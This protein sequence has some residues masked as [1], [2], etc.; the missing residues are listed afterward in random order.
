[1]LFA[2]QLLFH[3]VHQPTNICAVAQCNRA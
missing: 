3:Q 1:V 2:V